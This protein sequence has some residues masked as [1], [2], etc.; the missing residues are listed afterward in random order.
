MIDPEDIISYFEEVD[1]RLDEKVD[2]FILGGAFFS[3]FHIRS[4][5]PDIDLLVEKE[6]YSKILNLTRNIKSNLEIDLMTDR[7]L[8]HLRLPSDYKF[9]AKRYRRYRSN[10]SHIRLW[11]LSPMTF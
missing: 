9:K 7:W 6:H 2:V 8:D 11:T 4:G 5:S 1:K 3:L 10:F